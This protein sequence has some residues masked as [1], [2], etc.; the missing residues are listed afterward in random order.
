M[1]IDK[2]ATVRQNVPVIEGQVTQRRFSE[3]AGCMEY[4]VTY[5]DSDGNAAERWFLETQLSEVQP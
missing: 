2:G 5:T 4:L 1:P 3:D